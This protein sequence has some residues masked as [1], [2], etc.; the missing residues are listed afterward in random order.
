MKS[1]G[2]KIDQSF[3]ENESTERREIV[4]VDFS[5]FYFNAGCVWEDSWVCDQSHMG[6]FQ[7]HFFGGVAA[8]L[9]G[10]PGIEGSVDFGAADFSGH[11]NHHL[12]PFWCIFPSYVV[13]F[14]PAV[15][16]NARNH[17]Q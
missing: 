10:R 12:R 7:N 17:K 14:R 8:A 11:R 1:W 6:H 2:L 15:A 9:F 3:M 4:H 13:L 16:P 5:V